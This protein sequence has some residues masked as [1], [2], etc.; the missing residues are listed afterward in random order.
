M[1]RI[2]FWNYVSWREKYFRRNTIQNP[3]VG[4]SED[5]SHS[6]ICTLASFMYMYV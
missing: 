2:H 5:I 4:T 3:K 1:E 6:L